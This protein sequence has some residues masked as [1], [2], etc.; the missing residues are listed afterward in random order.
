MDY[1]YV[2][3][4]KSWL[5]DSLWY[6]CWVLSGQSFEHLL[7]PRKVSNAFF[8]TLIFLT[9]S[10]VLALKFLHDMS[11]TFWSINCCYLGL[12]LFVNKAKYFLSNE[13]KSNIWRFAEK[14]QFLNMHWY[15]VH[16]R[17]KW[18]INKLWNWMKVPTYDHL[19]NTSAIV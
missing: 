7:T 12:F 14:F 18:L 6:N 15:I 13:I 4:C 17:F 19:S 16:S 5:A 1:M 3:D 2:N 9:D 10:G 8:S 11:T